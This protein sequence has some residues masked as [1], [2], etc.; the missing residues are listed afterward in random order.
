MHDGTLAAPT[1]RAARPRPTARRDLRALVAVAIVSAGTLA[2]VA[3]SRAQ[4]LPVPTPAQPT[5]VVT[6]V[7][8]GRAPAETAEIQLLLGAPSVFGEQGPPAGEVTE[9]SGGA[10][11][12]DGTP[13][14]PGTPDDI[15]GGT[16]GDLGESLGRLEDA[17]ADIDAVS[18]VAVFEGIGGSGIV[19]VTVTLDDPT[20]ESIAALVAD[21]EDAAAETGLVVVAVGAAYDVAAC[22]PL[23]REAQAAA[24]GDGQARAEVLAELLGVS[25]GPLVQASVG[26]ASGPPA[27]DDGG[28]LGYGMNEY[29]GVSVGPGPGGALTVPVYNPATPTEATV[30]SQVTLVFAIEALDSATPVG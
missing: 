5:I 4:S 29:Y 27:G 23:Q 13:E 22:A 26:S 3:P 8:V 25:L 21:A 20:T 6:G 30:V 24:L 16:G 19:Q 28:C 12:T 14:V 11:S 15:T 7:G 1:L 18:E 10:A 9:E 17:L 2:T